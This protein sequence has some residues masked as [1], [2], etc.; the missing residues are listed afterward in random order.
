MQDDIRVRRNLTL[1]AGVRYEAQT[2]VRDYNNVMPRFG[3][4]W[5]PFASGAHDAAGELGHFLRLAV[6]QH[7][8]ADAA[9]R[10]LPPA[11]DRHRQS[12]VSRSA[13]RSAIAPPVNRYLLGDDVGAAANDA[14]QPGHRSAALAG[15]RRASTYTYTRGAALARGLNLN[16]PVDG[17]RP[18]PRVRQHHRGRL[19]RQLAAAPAAGQP[20]R[21]PGRAVSGD[22]RAAHQLQADDA[23]PQLHAGASCDNNTDGAF[24]V[25]ATGDLDSEW[26]PADNDVR[27]RL[28][29]TLNN[30]IVRNLLR[31]VQRQREQRRAV[32]AFAP[33]STT[34]AT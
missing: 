32:H 26:G 3:V 4:T 7:L 23:V 13:G 2:H 11:G 14:R 25:P 30:Q 24:S 20:H 33:A 31:R 34:T 28:N 27:H 15:C 6:D 18:D 1:S 5:A 10:R 8:R 16:A 12:G 17:V 21:Q 9:R 29:V 22:Q 19:R